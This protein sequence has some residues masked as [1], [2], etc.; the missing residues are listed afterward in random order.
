MESLK[1]GQA[2]KEVYN[3]RQSAANGLLVLYVRKNGLWVNRYGISVSRKVGNAV[4]RNRTRR[5]IKEQIRLH[6][7]ELAIGYDLVVIARVAAGKSDFSQIGQ[8]LLSLL[9][10]QNLRS[11]K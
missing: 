2:F 11:M 5:L 3:H 8:S 10:R 7:K 1:K 4:M 6:E 9:A